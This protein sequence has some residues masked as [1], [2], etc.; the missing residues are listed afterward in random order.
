MKGFNTKAIHGVSY[1]KKDIHG[2]LRPPIYDTVAF[3]FNSA[4]DHQLAFEGKKPSHAYSRI[5]N[6]T[7]EEFEHRIRLLTDALGVI[8]V[9]SGMAAITNIILTLAES[10]A[11]IITSKFLFGNTVSLFENTL[12]D[13]GLHV[14]YVDM[15]N[16]KEV[17]AKINENTRGIFLEVITNPQLEVADMQSIVE[18]ADRNKIP[19]I[20]D[21]TVTTPYLF[22]SKSFG[23]AIE[24]I[25][26]TKFI[27]GGA[28][29]VGGVIIDNGV[30]NWES[31]PKLQ[32]D[33][34]KYRQFTVVNKLRLEVFR[35]LGSC[36]APHHAYLHTLGLETLGMRIEKSCANTMEIAHF[37]NNHAKISSVTYPGLSHSPYHSIA[38]KQ[39]NHK[40]GGIL[41]FN[42]R[43]R[44]ACFKLMDSLKIIRR[45]TNL[46]DNKTLII[47]PASTIFC[48][49]SDNQK[50]EMKICDSM[51]RL[52]VGIEDVDDIIDDLNQGLENI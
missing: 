39:F 33:Y 1:L 31:C 36:L 37:L 42:L 13:W 20:L 9:S 27:S 29:S 10:G 50:K 19:V 25:S 17:E 7:V 5:T 6:P 51:L 15:G 16:Y 21:G 14:F 35:N 47:H 46:N 38:A 24:V 28:T 18:I 43:N 11:N 23:V 2:A 3:E 26:T 8:A 34:K 49:Y 40:F 45:T 22:N 32:N 4:R 41:T 30:F 52:A 48:E 12:K 44:E